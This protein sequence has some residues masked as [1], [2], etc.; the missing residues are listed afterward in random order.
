MKVMVIGNQESVLGFSLV[1]VGGLTASST[2][3]VNQALDKALSMTGIGIILVS[4]DVAKLIETRMND[5]KLRSTIPLVIEIPGPGGISSDEPSLSDVV[6][7][8]IGIKI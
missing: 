1:G 2:N 6:L 8:A 5:L 7:R 3:E 4:Q